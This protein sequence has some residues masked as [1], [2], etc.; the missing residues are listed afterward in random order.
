MIPGRYRVNK[1]MLS[2]ILGMLQDQRSCSYCSHLKV[3]TLYHKS[4]ENGDSTSAGIGQLFNKVTDHLSPVHLEY[5]VHWNRLISLE[6][7]AMKVKAYCKA[8]TSRGIPFS[9]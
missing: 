3:C 8:I 1:H 4:V 6:S 2:I 5:F 9:S 7:K